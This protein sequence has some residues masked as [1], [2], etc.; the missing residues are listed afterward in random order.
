MKKS[1]EE[2]HD[3]LGRSMDTKHCDHLRGLLDIR[4]EATH[5]LVSYMGRRSPFVTYLLDYLF[6]D[7][8]RT[9]FLVYPREW[10]LAELNLQ[11]AGQAADNPEKAF[12]RFGIVFDTPSQIGVAG[13]I[14][15]TY[16]LAFEAG[17]TQEDFDAW[18]ASQ[19]SVVLTTNLNRTLALVKR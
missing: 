4:R 17:M 9:G 18:E 15:V 12:A 7:R 3:P 19:D 6:G 8:G 14:T 16:P 11:D 2:V 10:K 1:I 5:E 13:S